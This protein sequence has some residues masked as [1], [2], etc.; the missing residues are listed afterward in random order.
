MNAFV[1]TLF[2]TLLSTAVVYAAPEKAAPAQ[3]GNAQAGNILVQSIAEQEVEVK[4]PN[5]KTEK[6]LQ[7]VTKAVPGSEVIYTTRFT[8]QGKLP[9]GNIAV[10]NP[11]P[12]NTVYVGGSAFGENTAITYSVDGKNFNTPDKLM[13]K[14]ADGKERPAVPTEYSAIR[15]TYKGELPAGKTSDVGFRVKIK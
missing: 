11:V 7:A 9:A 6:K 3:T 4:L 12:E 8:N 1:Q 13:T 14:A 10:T 2:I 5:G 15:W